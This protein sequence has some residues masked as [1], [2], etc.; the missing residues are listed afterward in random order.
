MGIAER[1]EREKERR[2]NDIL[3]A[4]EKVFF[5]RGA[6]LATMDE[7][8]EEAELSKGTLY[9]YFKSK[10]ALYLGIAARALKLLHDLFEEAIV[11]HSTGMQQSGAIGEVYYQFS[12][13]HPDYFDTILHY[14]SSKKDSVENNTLLEQCHQI[15]L[16]K[17][18]IVASTIENGIKDGTIRDDL[19][20]M[21]TAYV[22]RGA[23]TGIIQLI[24][25][26][27]KQIKDHERIS[28]EDL[29]NNFR[30]MMYHALKS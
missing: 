25:R 4:A 20:P 7:V 8:A 9:L 24:A 14:E 3:D 15:E 13:S 10:D 19:D 2:R 27:E 1:R 26:E 17:M 18:R 23:N 30:D 22:L 12:K 21:K 11:K 28:R 29:I 6:N 5:P 16:S